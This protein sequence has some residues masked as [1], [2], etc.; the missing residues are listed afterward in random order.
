M[1]D[2]QP[3]E[4][5]RWP[6]RRRRRGEGPPAV[7][8]RVCPQCKV[9]GPARL[10]PGEVCATCAAQRAWEDANRAGVLV[11][12]RA[13]IE[14]AVRRREGTR[15][16][17]WRRVAVW[18]PAGFS[19][20]AAVFTVV[21]LRAHLAP[22]EIGP[23]DALYDDLHGA[24]ARALWVGIGC[25][26]AGVI[27]LVRMRRRRH[28]R[29]LGIIAA[30]ALAIIAGATAIV[31]AGTALWGLR[32]FGGRFSTMPAREPLGVSPY[33]EQIASATVVML[34]PDGDGDARNLAIGSGAIVGGDATHAWIVTCSHVAMP[35][36]A[37]GSWRDPK[38]AQPVWVQLADGRAGR[39]YVRWAAPPPIDVAVVELAIENPPEPVRFAPAGQPIEPGA[40]VVFVPNPYRDGWLVHRGHLLRKDPHHSP[41]GT[42]ALLVTDLPLI[43]GDSGSGLFDARGQ[44]IGLNTWVK[45]MPGF[46]QGISLPAD[47]MAVL[48]DAIEHDNLDKLDELQQRMKER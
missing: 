15:E 20:A 25:T 14:A 13:S 45:V 12:D 37:V 28:F 27:L 48:A 10:S 36:A 35:Y 6:W 19:L 17:W 47:A 26:L 40:D 3:G 29:R 7:M 9:A 44:L 43:P 18:V 34:A 38:D 11:V 30:H 1:T 24:A 23:L 33:V 41:A 21:L 46:S 42:Y 22:R 5:R 16:P 4:R 39:A 8:S 32:T 31:L 2:D